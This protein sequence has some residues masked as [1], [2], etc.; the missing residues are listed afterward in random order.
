MILQPQDVLPSGELDVGRKIFYRPAVAVINGEV[1][2]WFGT[3]DRAHPLNH[4]VVDRLYQIVDK[5]QGTIDQID[6]K[7]LVDMTTDP[8]QTG[9]EATVTETLEKLYNLV[10]GPNS[11]TDYYRGFR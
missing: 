11:E 7:N 3:G 10:P 4:A 2:L 6:E 5:G 9:D 8:L 1:N